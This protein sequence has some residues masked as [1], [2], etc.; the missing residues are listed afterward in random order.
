MYLIHNNF[1]PNDFCGLCLKSSLINI[2]IEKFI[3]SYDVKER[4]L[5]LYQKFYY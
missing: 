5:K 2:Q 3:N 1:L 4:L